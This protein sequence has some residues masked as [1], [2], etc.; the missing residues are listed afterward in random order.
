VNHCINYVKQRRKERKVDIAE[1]TLESV[2]PGLDP[3]RSAQ[4]NEIRTRI[5]HT[6]L[7]LPPQQ[8]TVFLLK[9][10]EGMKY[11]EIS[12]TMGISVGTVKA[13][14]FHAVNK[15]RGALKDLL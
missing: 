9:H 4:S 6:V 12:H 8:R 10:Q 11:E 15:L 5:D 3:E 2:N 14:Y 13:H 1:V 7:E